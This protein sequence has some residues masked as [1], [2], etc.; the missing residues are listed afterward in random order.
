MKMRSKPFLVILL[1]AL[2]LRSSVI[3]SAE[4]A[5][6][7]FRI[8]NSV[9]SAGG[10]HTGSANYQLNDTIGQSSPLMNPPEPPLSDTYDLYPGFWY[11][12][13]AFQRTCPGDFDGDKDV[14][15]ADLADYLF[16]SGGIGLNVFADN[17]GKN[18]CP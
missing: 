8:R 5:S 10:Q 2:L 7:N 14:D 11:I 15:G 9:H 12:I 1:I 3:S 13:A 4:M 6:E 17:F 18:N 16:D